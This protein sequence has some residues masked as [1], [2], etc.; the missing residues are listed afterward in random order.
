MATEAKETEGKDCKSMIKSTTPF[1]T[2]GPR[3]NFLIKCSSDGILIDTTNSW[4]SIGID[5]P[6]NP[7]K[8]TSLEIMAMNTR[9]S[10]GGL[11]FTVGFASKG[12]INTPGHNH[13]G[14]Y[15]EG[16]DYHNN[17]QITCEHS[18]IGSYLPIALKQSF[19]LEIK[20]Y[21]VNVYLK[22]N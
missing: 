11:Y 12:V 8:T 6:I 1:N 2:F 3:D 15:M 14:H 9:T 5:H 20:Q 16:W 22:G 7:E 19:K 21:T 13:V 18:H 10:D 4:S 17:G